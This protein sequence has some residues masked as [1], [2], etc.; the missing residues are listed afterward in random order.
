MFNFSI[1]LSDVSLLRRLTKNIDPTSMMRS[2]WV[3]FPTV[4]KG[5]VVLISGFIMCVSLE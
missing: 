5:H 1:L 2:T 4:N 3:P